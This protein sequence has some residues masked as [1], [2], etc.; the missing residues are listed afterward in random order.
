[1]SC[2]VFQLF[3]DNAVRREILSLSVVCNNGSHGCVW[4]GELRDL[5]VSISSGSVSVINWNNIDI[6]IIDIFLLINLLYTFQN[7]DT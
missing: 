7:M 4:A 3:A 6:H 1:M 2:I 5:E